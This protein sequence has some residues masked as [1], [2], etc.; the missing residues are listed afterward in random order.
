LSVAEEVSDPM[1]KTLANGRVWLVTQPDHGKIA[2]Y[3][4]SHWGKYA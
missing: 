4:A 1:L 2:G 3:L